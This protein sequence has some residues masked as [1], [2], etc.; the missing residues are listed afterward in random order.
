[1]ECCLHIL[2]GYQ[3]SDRKG[4]EDLFKLEVIKELQ[5]MLQS[6][7]TITKN[8][9]NSILCL[10][11][12]LDAEMFIPTGLINEIRDGL[13]QISKKQIEFNEKYQK[14]NNY[15]PSTKYAVLESEFEEIYRILEEKSKQI[16]VINF[17]LSLHSED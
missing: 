6:M 9:D 10:K 12:V 5:Q 7:R 2:R 15:D 14:L 17:F 1:M 13:T 11:K 4:V 3:I 16:S 8:L